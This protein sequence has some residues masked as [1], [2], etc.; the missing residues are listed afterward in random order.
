MVSCNSWI[1]NSARKRSGCLIQAEAASEADRTMPGVPLSFGGVLRKAAISGSVWH[2]S[3]PFFYSSERKTAAFVTGLFGNSLEAP[4]DWSGS[5][6]F[7]G[8]LLEFGSRA[9]S[10]ERLDVAILPYVRGRKRF[11]MPTSAF[12]RLY[13]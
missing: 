5:P 10:N 3:L 8:K 6:F 4:G 9:R 7:A 12:V 11:P 13:I 2:C 1:P